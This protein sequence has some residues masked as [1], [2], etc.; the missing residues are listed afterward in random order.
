VWVEV[1]WP[2]ADPIGEPAKRPA[3]NLDAIATELG[4]IEQKVA[5]GFGRPTGPGLGAIEA[6]LRRILDEED[7]EYTYQAGSYQLHRVCEVD[8]NGNPL[9]P[10]SA[11]WP[12]GVGSL[13]EL[14]AKIDAI[15]LLLQHHK[16]IKQPVCAPARLPAP[17]GRPVTVTFEEI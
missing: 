4:R 10:L 16:V 15:A 12:A 3:P 6:L 1:P 7:D 9:P 17:Q 14:G 8:D 5:Q 11:P 13:A 2:G